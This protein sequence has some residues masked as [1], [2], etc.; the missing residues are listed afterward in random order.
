M[1]RLCSHQWAR[2]NRALHSSPM[3]TKMATAAG[4]GSLSDI[5]AQ[6]LEGQASFVVP[7]FLALA[8][9]NTFYIM[10]SAT[11]S[12]HPLANRRVCDTTFRG[13]ALC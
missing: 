10:D 13:T 2:Y 5:I 9:V 1:H 6:L 11:Y 7:R 12:G 4:L 8:F 3:L